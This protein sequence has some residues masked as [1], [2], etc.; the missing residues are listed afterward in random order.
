MGVA[1]DGVLAGCTLGA[2]TGAGAVDLLHANDVGEPWW[3]CRLPDFQLPPNDAKSGLA[4]LSAS[5]V[6]P[7]LHLLCG[8]EF[9]HHSGQLLPW[10][11][12]LWVC[13]ASSWDSMPL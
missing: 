11:A 3:E 9:N 7:A 6:T 5:A 10:L 4:V 8:C 13:C 1:A 12:Q 2:G